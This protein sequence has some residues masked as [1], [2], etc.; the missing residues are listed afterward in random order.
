MGYCW[1]EFVFVDVCFDCDVCL[2]C[3]W[4]CGCLCLIESRYGVLLCWDVGDEIGVYED[5][6]G[7]EYV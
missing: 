6:D 7:D 3:E 4:G 5:V 1:D 2:M